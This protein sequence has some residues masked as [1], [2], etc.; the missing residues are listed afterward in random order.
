[1]ADLVWYLGPHAPVSEILNKLELI[2]GTVAS[3][4][5]LMQ[6]FYKLQQGKTEKVL[7]YVTHLEGALNAVQ[8]ESSMMLSTF[9]VQMHLRYCPFHGLHKHL[10]DSMHYLY[11]NPRIMYP[12]LM[13]AAHKAESEQ[14]G[15]PR[16]GV[17]VRSA[18][19]EARDNIVHLREQIV[20]FYTQQ[21]LITGECKKWE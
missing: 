3:F 10:H 17:Q 7:V 20:Q 5:I 12:Q 21:P 13:T 9:K 14:E 6:N 8:Q 1:M 15:R 4:D 11:N 2:Y 16:E 19:S 18:Q